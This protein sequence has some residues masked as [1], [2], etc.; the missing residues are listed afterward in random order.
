MNFDYFIGIDWSGNKNHHQ[1]NIAV[2][3]CSN[4]DESPT[5]QI[6]P[7]YEKGA[8]SRTDV[9]RWIES[10]WLS[11]CFAL[12]G[13]DF[14]FAFPYCDCQSYFPYSDESPRNHYA[15][16]KEVDER[17]VDNT[18]FYGRSFFLKDSPYAKYF[19][20]QGLLKGEKF[21]ESNN[22]RR[23][24]EDN[25]HKYRSNP[26]SI[27]N[28]AYPKQVGLSSLAG[29]RFLC[30][31]YKKEPDLVAIW[32][33]HFNHQ[34]ISTFVEIYPSLYY[35]R[36]NYNRSNRLELV[37]K[38]LHFYSSNPLDEKCKLPTKD[39]ADAIISAAALRYFSKHDKYWNPPEMDDTAR[40]YEGWIFGV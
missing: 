27:F 13:F 23:I 2:A 20:L 40:R 16:W 4:D 10:N 8:W 15:L 35:K 14:A 7:Y 30:H 34:N 11:Q 36:A 33:F 3:I 32:P 12:I 18:N 19:H 39:E 29:M 17:C 28:C 38:V 1:K 24:T 37:N 6:N 5:I 26:E 31:F 21:D 22:R 9:A 25:C